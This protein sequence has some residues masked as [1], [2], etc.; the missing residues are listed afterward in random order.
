METNRNRRPSLTTLLLNVLTH[1]IHA[2]KVKQEKM[3][4]HLIGQT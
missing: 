3:S 4:S 1:K 2:E